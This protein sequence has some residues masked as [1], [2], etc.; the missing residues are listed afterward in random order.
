M[1]MAA[2]GATAARQKLKATLFASLVAMGLR[3]ISQYA[4]GV[5]WVC[6]VS[7]TL[8]YPTHGR[9]VISIDNHLTTEEVDD[10]ISPYAYI[11]GIILQMR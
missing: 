7:L 10:G 9:A 11:P 6:F 5:L 1:H 8:P 2:T 3:V 4:I